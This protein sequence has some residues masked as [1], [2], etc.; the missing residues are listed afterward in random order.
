[1]DARDCWTDRL[2]AGCD[3]QLIEW[4][5]VDSPGIKIADD[6]ATPVDVDGFDVMAG[7][8]VDATLSELLRGTGDKGADIIDKTADVVGHPSGRV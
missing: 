7:A 5:A 8:G 2:G 6:D 3:H 1:V 4:F